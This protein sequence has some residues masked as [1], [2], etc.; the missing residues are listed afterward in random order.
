MKDVF[1]FL[2]KARR[3]L[4][5]LAFTAY[6]RALLATKT[7]SLN[8]SQEIGRS[9]LDSGINMEILS[10]AKASWFNQ[11]YV[12]SGNHNSET[13]M[14]QRLSYKRANSSWDLLY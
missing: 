4:P 6:F 1:R 8:L 2:D 12:K 5:T 7:P 3:Y 13:E 9:D 14:L 10:F 11:R